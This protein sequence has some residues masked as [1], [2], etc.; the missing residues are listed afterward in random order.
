M[1]FGQLIEEYNMRNI[2]LEKSWTK[3]GEDTI[4]RPFSAEGQNWAYL[5]ISSLKICTAGLYC[6]PSWG[7]LKYIETKLQTTSFYLL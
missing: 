3:Y 4:P 7:L 2:F 5:W 1:K 6:I